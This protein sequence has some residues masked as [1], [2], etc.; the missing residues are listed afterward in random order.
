[1]THQLLKT[2]KRATYRRMLK[3]IPQI[4]KLFLSI[5]DLVL[6]DL[7]SMDGIFEGEAG[8]QP[9][10]LQTIKNRK[11]FLKICENICENVNL[12][13]N[14]WEESLVLVQESKTLFALASTL[15]SQLVIGQSFPN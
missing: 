13:K 15:R 9:Q 3:T 8:I 6:T 2:R 10:M 12:D 14:R 5:I 4:I 11:K 7:E 1:M